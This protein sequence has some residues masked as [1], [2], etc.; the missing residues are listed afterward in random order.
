VDKNFDR[1]EI[2]TLQLDYDRAKREL[3]QAIRQ[4]CPGGS[5]ASLSYPKSGFTQHAGFS[6]AHQILPAI[7]SQVIVSLRLT[8]QATSRRI[9]ATS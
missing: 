3:R 4:A 6:T 8:P 5:G 2:G 7:V 9:S 1:K